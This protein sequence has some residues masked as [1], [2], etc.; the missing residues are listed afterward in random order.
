MRRHNLLLVALTWVWALSGDD[1]VLQNGRWRYWEGVDNVR[2]LGGLETSDGLRVRKGLVFRSQ[3]FNDNALTSR[4]SGENLFA[5]ISDGQLWTEFGQRTGWEIAR[6]MNVH[7]IKGSC[8]RFSELLRADKSLWRRGEAR[9]TP[10]SRRRILLETGLKTEIDLRSDEECWGMEGSPLGSTVKWLH[11]P[12]KGSSM[13]WL[14]TAEGMTYFKD[15]FNVFAETNNYPIVFHCIAG[16]DRTGCIAVLLEGLLGIADAQIV[17]DYLMTSL[18][19]SRSRPKSQFDARMKRFLEK[20]GASCAEKAMFYAQEC[21]I[22]KDSL[23]SFRRFLL[24]D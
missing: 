11:L 21:S 2:D 13:D 15:L 9:G 19:S 23:A 17:E 22:G 18:S 16:A 4:Y 1:G 8:E 10:E 3:A 20:P 24:E 6:R 7:D 5:R 14:M 12:C